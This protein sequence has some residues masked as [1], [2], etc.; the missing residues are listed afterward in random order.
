MEENK[1]KDDATVTSEAT[2]NFSLAVS[3]INRL[4]APSPTSM[5]VSSNA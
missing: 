2:K 3:D 1:R 4:M 5:F